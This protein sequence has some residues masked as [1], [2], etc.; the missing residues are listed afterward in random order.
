[1]KAAK[2]R[3][4]FQNSVRTAAN[5]VAMTRFLLSLKWN[6]CGLGIIFQP[7][8]LL[9]TVF[10]LRV[11][12][13]MASVARLCLEADSFYIDIPADQLPGYLHLPLRRAVIAD[14]INDDFAYMRT[15][16]LKWQLEE[17][18]CLFGLPLEIVVPRLG[19]NKVYRF[20]REELLIYFLQRYKDGKAHIK[21][22]GDSFYGGD[23]AR[24][25]AGVNYMTD[26]LDA[27]YMHLLRPDSIRYWIRWIPYFAH[28]V[29]QAVR[30]RRPRKNHNGQIIGWVDGIDINDGDCF[31]FSFTDCNETDICRPGSGPSGDFP[32][33]PRKQNWRVTQ[34]A[35]F[36]GHHGGHALKCLTLILPNGLEVAI[37]G[38]LSCRRNDRQILRWADIDEFLSQILQ[39]YNLGLYGSYAD[40]IFYGPWRCFVTRHV[41]LP[42]APLTDELEHENAIMN[43]IRVPIEWNYGLKDRLWQLMR[44]RYSKKLLVNAERVKAEIR[45]AHLLTNIYTCYNGSQVSNY[46][47]CDPPS[48]RTYLS[49]LP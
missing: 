25:G 5:W 29:R 35:V 17:L 34:Q 15:N 2:Y 27:R 12:E 30:Q 33:A 16:F 44:D 6:L 41:D 4:C 32:F 48:A 19:T 21:M 7:K 20:N 9:M 14:F 31:V 18:V 40:S 8:W 24:W 26:Y 46:F 10:A 3:R 23:S 42:G 13:T 37:F 38:P 45:V 47:D 1:M 36:G 11:V 22:A 43:K 28:K 39:Q 49:L